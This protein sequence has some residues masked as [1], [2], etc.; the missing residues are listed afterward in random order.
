MPAL[1]RCTGKVDDDAKLHFKTVSQTGGGAGR[2]P[3]ESSQSHMKDLQ[4][5]KENV[6][7]ARR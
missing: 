2:N 4:E 5:I 1:G 6:H 7:K 3:L